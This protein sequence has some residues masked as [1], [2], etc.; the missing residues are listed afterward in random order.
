MRKTTQKALALLLACTMLFTALCIPASANSVQSVESAKASA[1]E[2]LLWNGINAFATALLRTMCFF[3]P[4]PHFESYDKYSPE[5]VGILPGRDTFRTT[6][7]EQA[8][9][10]L[11]YGRESVIP[12]DFEAGKYYMGRKLNLVSFQSD[13]KATDILDDQFCRAVA[14]NDGTSDGAVAIA[15]IDGIG[16][17]ST[18]IREI[19]KQ[20]IAKLG[21]DAFASINVSATHCHS[22]IDTQGVSSSFLQHL[23]L[24]PLFNILNMEIPGTECERDFKE[25]LVAKSVKAICTAYE[26]MT[27]GEMYYTT[28][29][30]SEYIYDKKEPIVPE[31]SNIAALRF[32]PNDET[33]QGTY[34][35]N[36]TAHPTSYSYRNTTISSDYPYYMDMEFNA[37]GFNFILLT[38]AIGQIGRKT[39]SIVVPED[40]TD[41]NYTVK[42]YGKAL[43]DFILAG[44]GTAEEKL[45]PI[46]NAKHSDFNITCSNYLLVLAL[47]CRLVNNKA[48]RTGLSPNSCVLP[49]EVGYIEL[50]GRVGFGL[51]PAELYP[52]VYWGNAL[53]GDKAWD[54]TDWPYNG[55]NSMSHMNRDGVDMYPICFANDYIGYVV[56]DN[57]FAFIAHEPDELLSIGKNT[58]STIIKAFASLMSE[59]K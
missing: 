42:A 45:P 13:A 38:G 22:V 53:D 8:Q 24:A 25:V 51:F 46:V 44:N 57:D 49:T 3:Y 48:F 7:A 39:D 23:F 31:C 32:E 18:E 4:N 47:K 52:E 34:M 17:T 50:G 9:W 56:P 10:Q 11:G 14:I 40:N 1:S 19:R 29:D 28:L 27:A 59:V 26:N 33:V 58:A 36:M 37:N 20:V 12:D 6:A 30:G 5:K 54:G 21:E 2:K 43:A 41:P 35:V 55:E 16:V 15:V